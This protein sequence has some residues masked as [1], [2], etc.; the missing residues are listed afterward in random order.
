MR[1]AGREVETPWGRDDGAGAGRRVGEIWFE[2]ANGQELPLLVKYLFTAEPLSV[3]VHPNEAAARARGLPHGKSE[4][5]YVVAA[6]PGA[7]I[8]LGFTRA[9]S[10]DALR[11]AAAD[12]SIE[13]EM[14]WHEAKAGDFFSVPAGT[15]HAIGAGLTLIEVQQPSDVTYRLHDYGRGRTLHLDEAVAVADRGPYREPR[16]RGEG[17]LLDGPHFA[18]ARLAPGGADPFAGRPRFLLPLGPAPA[19]LY[20][21]PGEPLAALGG[22]ALLAAAP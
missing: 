12:G 22:P 11:A 16:R 1:L 4:C 14:G 17:V 8:G 20:L 2:A 15:V 13:R 6:E 18:V 5:W 7:R 3:Q 9:L 21:E 19:C 10:A